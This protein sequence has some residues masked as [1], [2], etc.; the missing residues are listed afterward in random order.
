M[1]VSPASG[2]RKRAIIAVMS[3]SLLSGLLSG[4]VHAQSV[5]DIA[6]IQVNNTSLTIQGSGFGSLAT[7]DSVSV[8]NLNASITSWNG[9]TIVVSIPADAGPGPVTVTSSSGTSNPVMFSGV[10]RGYYT[11]SH[12]GAVTAHGNIPFYGQLSSSSPHSS[13]IQIVSTPTRKGYWILTQNGQI[14]PFGDAANLG[15]APV[16]ANAVAMAPTPSGQG[17]FVLDQNGTVYA[18]GDARI[19]GNAPAGTAAQAIAVTPDGQG[20]WILAQTGTVYS[21]G[22]AKN[23]GSA[24]LASSTIQSA[25]P[26]GSLLQQSNTSSVFLLSHGT[27]HHIPNP[28]ILFGLGYNWSSIQ[29]VPSLR[30]YPM[31][32]PLVVPYPSGSLLQAQGHTSVYLVASGVMH[33]IATAA[34]FLEMGFK[35]N[36]IQT[37]PAIQ[38]SWPIGPDLTVPTAY[39]PSG[40]IIKTPDSPVVYMVSNSQ[41][42]PISSASVFLAMGY[43]WNQIQTVPKLPALPIAAPMTQPNRAYPTGSLIRLAGHASVYLVQNGVLRHILSPQALFSL[44]Y[45]FSQVQVVPTLGSLPA[46]PPLESTTIPAPPPESNPQAIS[47]VPSGDGLGYWILTQN[48]QV[49]AF[50]DAPALGQLSNAQLG[51]DQATG[52]ALTP[53]YQG[54]LIQTASG[55]VYAFGDAQTFGSNSTG[56]HGIVVSPIPSGRFMSMGY[57]FFNAE[58]GQTTPGSYQDFQQNAANMSVIMPNWFFVQQNPDNTWRLNNWTISMPPINGLTE[59]Q[60]VIQYAHQQHVLVMPSIGVN[61]NPANGPITT[62]QDVSSMVSQIVGVVQS[63]QFDGITIDFENNSNYLSQGMTTAQASDQYTQFIAQL[64][65]ALHALGKKLMV[66]V[67]PSSYPYTIYNYGALAPYVDYLNMM[68]YPQHNAKTYPGPTAGYP[69][70]QSCVQSAL[71]SGINP[72]QIVM[73]VA[74]YGHEWTLTNASGLQGD[75]WISNRG[76]QQ[77]LAQNSIT[78]LWDPVQKEIVFTAGPPADVPQA[79]LSTQNVST[80][81]PQV[82]NLQGLLN[83]ILLRYNIEHGIAERPQ[84]WLDGQYGSATASAVAAFQQDFSVSGATSGLYDTATQ[85]ALAQVIQQWNIGQNVYWD[86]TSRSFKD[87]LQLAIWDHLAGVASWRLP[88]ET[89]GYWQALSTYATVHHN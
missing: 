69:W 26:D 62:S 88:F 23:Y 13:A 46:G 14:F 20:Y 75:P 65:P 3:G 54:Y 59:M 18:L 4:L 52:L 80:T 82:E 42:L 37:V 61:Y 17:A 7:N 50:G 63:N 85:Q 44:G 9:T 79:P 33:H 56:H 25:Y 10:E 11:L 27:L 22:D 47:L 74:P 24:G 43:Q 78:P 5:P 58:P 81:L 84:L 68:T 77:I 39:E 19:L 51:S 60:T 76:I 15:N 55:Q 57:G 32:P 34:V 64:G 6:R 72:G 89:S 12:T 1:R 28:S 67:Y 48:G 71:A 35:W 31:G 53:D 66:A 8:N 16:S 83:Y 45:S 73:G 2:L 38:P 41:L 49:Q 36:Q 40:S 86:E 30:Q 21:F 70:V 87:R 29:N